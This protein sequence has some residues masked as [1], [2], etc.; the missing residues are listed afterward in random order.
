MTQ[1]KLAKDI[2]CLTL[3]NRNRN[4]DVSERS[5]RETYNYECTYFA[6]NGGK[7]PRFDNDLIN[8]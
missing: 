4:K 6:L 2:F 8:G 7:C 3:S 1:K 5:L